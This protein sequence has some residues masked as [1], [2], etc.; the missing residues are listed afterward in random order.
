MSSLN[1]GQVTDGQKA[2]HKSPPCIGTGVLKNIT[3]PLYA[4]ICPCKSL[5][6]NIMAI[7]LDHWFYKGQTYL[8]DS[9]YKINVSECILV[10]L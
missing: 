1:F 3:E 2:M 7:I 10:T 6:K 9:L 8:V 4:Y 5:Y